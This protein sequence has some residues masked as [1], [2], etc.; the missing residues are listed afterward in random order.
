MNLT[1]C[2]SYPKKTLMLCV[3]YHEGSVGTKAGLEGLAKMTP[4][5]TIPNITLKGS[6]SKHDIRKLYKKVWQISRILNST[7]ENVLTCNVEAWNYPTV[8]TDVTAKPNFLLY[9]F[10][11]RA[12]RT[13]YTCSKPTNAY[14]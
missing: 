14:R 6:A 3:H 13:I 7:M 11:I 9:V 2:S 1:F 10:N 8:G 12:L 4:L 5:V